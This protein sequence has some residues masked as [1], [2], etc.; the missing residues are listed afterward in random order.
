MC[1]LVSRNYWLGMKNPK[2]NKW[3]I[4]AFLGRILYPPLVYVGMRTVPAQ[5]F[6]FIGLALLGLRLLALRGRDD[7]RLWQVAFLLVAFVLLSLLFLN[8][9]LAVK[10]YP[11]LIS[12]SVAAIFAFSLKFPPTMVERM[13]RVTHPHLSPKAVVYTRK[14][15]IVWV[16]FLLC[17]TF[18]S[19]VTALWC[20]LDVWTLWNGFLSY[21]FMGLLFLGEFCVRRLVQRADND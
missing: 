19:A 10:A 17:N 7:Q 11:L 20:S 3:Y 15:T 4:A 5:I 13:A 8:G 12:L 9:Q 16:A 1:S 2:L 14:V 21:I 6:V 18:I